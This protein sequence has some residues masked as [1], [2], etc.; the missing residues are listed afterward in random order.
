MS[1]KNPWSW[2]PT[3]YFAEGVPY[4]I[5]MTV[6][7]VMYK[8]LGIS[9]T[10]IALYTSWLYLPWVIKPLWSPIVDMAGTRR[11]WV[12]AMQWLIGAGFAAIAFSL[13]LSNFFACSLAAFWLVAFLS[14]TRHSSRRI[15]YAGVG[16]GATI[17][18]CGYTLHF[19]PHSHGFG[20][21]RVSDSSGHHRNTIPEL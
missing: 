15:L 18:F 5:V 11:G 12:I 1:R 9:N 19:L 10:D 20:T 7:V 21:R 17:L 6:A 8:K 16:S 4:A 13:P 2:V 14:A 3:L